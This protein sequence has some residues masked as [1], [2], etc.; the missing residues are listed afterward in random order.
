MAGP[1]HFSGRDHQTGFDACCTASRRLAG[2][3]PILT[4]LLVIFLSLSAVYHGWIH[5][6]GFWEHG[7]IELVLFSTEVACLLISYLAAVLRGP[8]FVPFGWCP[9]EEE[10]STLRSSLDPAGLPVAVEAPPV[11]DLLQWCA[12]CKGYKPPRAHHCS[13]CGRCVLSMDH[14]CP[15]TNTCIGQINM[16]PFV[17]FVHF[18]PIATLH[19]LVVHS[20]LFILLVY[21]WKN[22]RKS[23][24]FVRVVIRLRILLGLIA[25][26]CCLVVMLLVGTLAWEMEHT[27][28]GNISMIEEYV[29]EKAEMRRRRTGE[30]KFVYPYDLGRKENFAAVLGSSFSWLVPGLATPGEPVW[31]PVR[32]G[33]THFDISTEQ[34]A[35]KM[36]KLQRSMVMPVREHF[37]GEG[38]CCLSYW[39]WICFRFGCCAAC[40]CEACGEERLSVEPG[41]AVLI[42]KSEGSWAHGRKMPDGGLNGTGITDTSDVP[43]GWL[44][45]RVLASS[46]AVPYEIPFQKELQG[47]WEAADGRVIVVKGLVARTTAS[48][49]PF[50][51]RHEAGAVRLLGISLEACDGKTAQWCGGEVWTKQEKPVPAARKGGH[52][53]VEDGLDDVLDDELP[54]LQ[55]VG[56]DSK[57]DD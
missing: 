4:I 5:P 30:R 20:E 49:M 11:S 51:L 38:R 13:T 14:H 31:P 10:L 37:T 12:S 18:V 24:D 25:W 45:R 32:A 7:P 3:P 53:P 16:K 46:E 36:E 50:V 55:A 8:G 35:Q 6:I 48:N 23:M 19:A 26:F 56:P 42:S 41:Q 27:V 2:V 57:K 34:I 39:C 17:Q 22:S 28:V 9:T 43:S 54:A 33:C 29:L 1:T 44:P 47:H 15:W 52:W 21:G 40:D